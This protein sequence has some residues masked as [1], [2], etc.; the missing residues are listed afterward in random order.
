MAHPR[1]KG[2]VR[3][4]KKVERM[5]KDI[6]KRKSEAKEKKTSDQ[7]DVQAFKPGSAGDKG[8]PQARAKDERGG[9]R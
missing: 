1:K 7:W 5:R 4:D 2:G 6:E 8:N 9:K 3:K